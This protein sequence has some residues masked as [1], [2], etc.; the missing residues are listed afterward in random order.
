MMHL[1]VLKRRKW[2]YKLLY[3]L[4]GGVPVVTQYDLHQM[5]A[6]KFWFTKE[7]VDQA[8]ASSNTYPLLHAFLQGQ[9]LTPVLV[10]IG[11]GNFRIHLAGAAL[12]TDSVLKHPMVL[13]SVIDL[14]TTLARDMD[15]GPIG[16][17]WLYYSRHKRNGWDQEFSL[18][19]GVGKAKLNLTRSSKFGVSDIDFKKCHYITIIIK[20]DPDTLKFTLRHDRHGILIPSEGDVTP[21]NGCQN[22][23]T[24]GTLTEMGVTDVIPVET[25]FTS[26]IEPKH[27]KP[28]TICAVTT[29]HVAGMLIT[30]QLVDVAFEGHPRPPTISAIRALSTDDLP[31]AEGFVLKDEAGE[32][33]QDY[34]GPSKRR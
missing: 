29:A 17:I 20:H 9:Q 4:G 34:E 18:P 19:L 24:T 11:D 23:R 33:T 25:R 8:L 13:I 31:I 2:Y 6:L 7:Y 16:T 14:R 30:N 27:N 12:T 28:S 10:K 22:L 3:P 1:I 26:A 32:K 15:Y 5:I 21:D